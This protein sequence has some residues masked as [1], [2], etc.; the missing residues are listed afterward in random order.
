MFIFGAAIV[1]VIEA[2]DRLRFPQPIANTE[3]SVFAMVLVIILKGGLVLYQQ[4]VIRLTGSIVVWADALHYKADL[5]IHLGIVASLAIADEVIASVVTAF[6][7][8]EVQI[9]EEAQAC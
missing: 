3:L 6:P 2:V 7:N 1:I 5:L 9:H 4:R 8:T